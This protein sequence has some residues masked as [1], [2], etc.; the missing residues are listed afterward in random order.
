MSSTVSTL[1]SIVPILTTGIMFGILIKSIHE[2]KNRSEMVRLSSPKSQVTKE[3]DCRMYHNDESED[4]EVSESDEKVFKSQMKRKKKAM[5]SQGQNSSKEYF[6]DEKTLQNSPG[7]VKYRGKNENGDLELFSPME[8]I[9]FMICDE[10]EVVLRERQLEHCRQTAKTAKQKEKVKQLEIQYS[11]RAYPLDARANQNSQQ[12]NTEALYSKIEASSA[13]PEASKSSP[14]NNESNMKKNKKKTRYGRVGRERLRRQREFEAKQQAA[15]FKLH[16]ILGINPQETLSTAPKPRL[17]DSE[18]TTKN[19]NDLVECKIEKRYQTDRP[20]LSDM[21][22]K[23]IAEN[24][25][26]E[27]QE[28]NEDVQP[29]AGESKTGTPTILDFQIQI[30]AQADSLGTQRKREESLPWDH[31]QHRHDSF[32]EAGHNTTRTITVASKSH[33]IEEGLYDNIEEGTL[34]PYFVDE[35]SFSEEIQREED[36]ENVTDGEDEDEVP[37]VKCTN[38]S[39]VDYYNLSNNYDSKYAVHLNDIC[40]TNSEGDANFGAGYSTQYSS[41]S[42]TGNSDGSTEECEESTSVTDGSESEEESDLNLRNS[43][44]TEEGEH[45]NLDEYDMISDE[46]DF[47]DQEQMNTHNRASGDLIQGAHVGSNNALANSV[48][49]LE[50]AMDD[51]ELSWDE[52][53]VEDDG[54]LWE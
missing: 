13:K 6:P 33:F 11:K 34:G 53:E 2:S 9:S 50:N 41:S 35:L 37:E 47:L 54:Q 43:S 21:L 49:R 51:E 8:P 12:K 19:N 17:S 32:C 1:V 45:S 52:I 39:L 40:R 38:S 44:G 46:N 14:K 15:T 36:H 4:E 3:K 27:K 28:P 16:E 18:R 26:K 23:E 10:Q 20:N 22:Q 42:S 7:S 31:P 25:A 29:Q 24:E 48:R 5:K 30:P